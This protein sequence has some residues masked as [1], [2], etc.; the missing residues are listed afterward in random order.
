M[1]ATVVAPATPE[2]E[3]MDWNLVG[4]NPLISSADLRQIGSSLGD[5]HVA[6]RLAELRCASRFRSLS[7]V[8]DDRGRM[9]TR[10]RAVIGRRELGR[11]PNVYLT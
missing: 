10:R 11:Q 1:S 6:A 7:G 8:A 3:S 9:F 5:R 2:G 4:L